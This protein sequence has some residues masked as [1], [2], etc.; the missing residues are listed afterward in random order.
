MLRVGLTGGLGSGKSTV[1]GLLRELGA[2]VVEA[3]A[4]GRQVMEPGQQVY[5]EIVRAFGPEVVGP[6]GRLNRARLAQLAFQDGRLN[7]LNAIVHPAVIAAQQTWVDAVF[8][9]DPAA[10]AVIESALI[11]EV[12]RD[13]RARGERQGMLADWRRRIDRILLVTAPDEL[14]IARYVARINPPATAREAVEA[15]ARLRLSHQIPDAEKASMS[16]YVIDNKS[17]MEA[18]RAQ[19]NALWQLLKRDSNNSPRDLSLK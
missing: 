10:V 6:D 2:E 18:L 7:D 19:V 3:D 13:A 15:D 8:A 17:D 9:R 12:V 1:A 11:F 4:L 5:Q 16:D 14:K